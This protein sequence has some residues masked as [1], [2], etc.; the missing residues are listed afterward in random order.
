MVSAV[1]TPA[2]DPLRSRT[3]FVR[4]VLV[5]GLCFVSGMALVVALTDGLGWHYLL[6]TAA[7]M[8]AANVLGWWLN[9]SWTYALRRRRTLAEFL[10]YALVNAA[11]MAM[12]LALV[13]LLVRLGWHYLPACA[14]VSVLMAVV[15]FQAHGRVSLRVRQG[16]GR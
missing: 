14:A 12:S 6:S 16:D 9:R 11:G 2:V 4:F 3:A 15:N 7:A 1:T 10:R 5:G 13:A 8:V